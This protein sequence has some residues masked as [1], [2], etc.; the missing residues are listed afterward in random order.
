MIALTV[1]YYKLKMMLSDRLLT[2]T[3]IMVPVILAVL[4]GYAL[5]YEK[6]G[7]IPVAIADEDGSRLSANFVQRLS[8]KEGLRVEKAVR[9]LAY[10][11]VERNEAELAFIIK[12]GFEKKLLNGETEGIIDVLRSPQSFSAGL[13]CEV[14]AGEAMRFAADSMAAKWVVERYNA[15]GRSKG[16]ELFNEVFAHADSYWEPKPLMTVDYS[17]LKGGV[18]TGTAMVALP[19]ASAA[20]TGILTLFVMLYLLVGSGWLI[21][22]RVNNTI[23]RVACGPGALASMFIGNTGTLL[24]AGIL[25]TIIVTSVVKLVSDVW[26][27]TGLVSCLVFLLYIA[28]AAAI[29]TLMSAVLKTPAQLQAG[30]PVLALLSGIAGGCL[31]NFQ[32]LSGSIRKISFFTP[33]GWALEGLNN[34]AAGTGEMYQA[35]IPLMVLSAITLILLP[36]SYIIIRKTL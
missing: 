6:L 29:A 26:L 17:E 21:E 16:Q 5:K 24:I 10:K 12:P 14:A 23:K 15:T 30:A 31:W 20:S 3:M 1:I 33:Q 7:V 13:V 11:L 27:F 8:A 25:Q 4:A 22:E 28:S 18:E 19:S 36:L 2:V 34:L 9:K 35:L 32:G